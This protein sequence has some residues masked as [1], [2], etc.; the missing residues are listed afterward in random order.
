MEEHFFCDLAIAGW[1]LYGNV[2][3]NQ[4]A[5]SDKIREYLRCLGNPYASL[6]VIDEVFEYESKSVVS[7]ARRAHIRALQNPYANLAT[8][9]DL[10]ASDT[11]MAAPKSMTKSATVSKAAFREG[12]RSIFLQYIPALERGGRV[13]R[14][15]HQDFI[16]R[17][18]SR[19]PAVR[20]RLLSELQKYNLSDLQG[21]STQFNRE[22]ET[23]TEEKLK[24]IERVAIDE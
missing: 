12:C 13:L 2:V 3:K 11:D 1:L 20:Y 15:Y 7:Q 17:N 19:S 14:R 10:S 22:K 4:S 24:L 8:M 18:E 23:L 5:N 6:Q 16:L 21:L 9:E